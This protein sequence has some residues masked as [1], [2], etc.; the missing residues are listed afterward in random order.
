MPSVGESQV[1]LQK[2]EY[3]CG[4][5]SLYCL[6]DNGEKCCR[7]IVLVEC[8]VKV[9]FFCCQKRTSGKDGF[10]SIVEQKV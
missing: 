7:T 5:N 10:C 1:C 6:N 9:A 4:T 3:Y 2:M 8:I